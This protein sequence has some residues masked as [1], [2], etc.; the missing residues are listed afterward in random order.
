MNI[1]DGLLEI[2]PEGHGSRR[3][4]RRTA[5][6]ST[7]IIDHDETNIEL[8]QV[9]DSSGPLVEQFDGT[10]IPHHIAALMVAFADC[11]ATTVPLPILLTSTDSLTGTNNSR[12]GCRM[13]A[14]ESSILINQ[15]LL[16]PTPAAPSQRELRK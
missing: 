8:A 11:S 10:I 14:G 1:G 12:S 15:G 6:E 4:S 7:D 5:F 2:R 13:S 9:M 3:K 16:T